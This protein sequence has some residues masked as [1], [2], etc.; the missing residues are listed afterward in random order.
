MSAL[1]L[2]WAA[3]LQAI[4]QNGLLFT[5]DVFDKERYQLIQKIA[6]EMLATHTSETAPAV[7]E[8]FFSE[9]RGY[10]TPK[11][12]VR[13]AVFQNDKI[14]LVQEKADQLWSLP[15][16]WCD[17]GESAS[18]CVVK[19]IEQEAGLKTKAIKLIGLYDKYSHPYPPQ[20]PHIYKCFFLC[21]VIGGTCNPGVETLAAQFFSKED[22]PPL[23]MDRIILSH[24]LRCFEHAQHF[25]CPTDFD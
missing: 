11:L 21:E 5:E 4:A 17:V 19:E 14:L 1:W 22:L 18:R 7:V 20:W 8:K 3:E 25:E 2:K 9:E 24:I 10:A 12:D 16:G 23:S 15:G 6:S 13:G